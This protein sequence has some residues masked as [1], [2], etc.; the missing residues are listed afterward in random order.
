MK[1]RKPGGN[2]ICVVLFPEVAILRRESGRGRPVLLSYAR[3][4]VCLELCLKHLHNHQASTFFLASVIEFSPCDSV[5][6]P[7][8]CLAVW[9]FT[10]PGAWAPQPLP[11][12]SPRRLV[13]MFHPLPYHLTLT[14]VLPT[15]SAPSA[16][17][18]SGSKRAPLGPGYSSGASYHLGSGKPFTAVHAS[19]IPSPCLILDSESC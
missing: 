14:P 6:I 10:E 15:P 8:P 7:F 12:L 3:G 5:S 13:R 2:S 11:V 1:Y 4:A 16:S 19:S 9:F 18:S 17:F